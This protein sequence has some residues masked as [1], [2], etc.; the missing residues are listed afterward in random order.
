MNVYTTLTTDNGEEYPVTIE[1]VEKLK[2]DYGEFI[3]VELEFKKM[4][5]WIDAN[6]DRRKTARGMKRFIT[7]WILR[8][9]A[10]RERY[11]EPLG[12][13]SKDTKLKEARSGGS[14][15]VNEFFELA[16]K[17]SYEDMQK[18]RRNNTI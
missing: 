3:S 10:D 9:V 5:S 13:K 12:N 1:T 14:F 11:R 6:P 15:D 17:A 8:A 4:R 7:S 2:A 18:H 16:V